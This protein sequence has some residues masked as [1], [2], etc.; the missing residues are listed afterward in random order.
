MWGVHTRAGESLLFL[1]KGM[2]C[3]LPNLLLLFWRLH[4]GILKT[5]FLEGESGS[6]PSSQMW[7]ELRTLWSHPLTAPK[8][9]SLDDSGSHQLPGREAQTPHLRQNWAFPLCCGNR[10]WGMQSGLSGWGRSC[11]RQDN[12][13]VCPR[14][15]GA[16]H[17]R[18][19][20]VHP[21]GSPRS[22]AVTHELS[23]P[24]LTV[25]R[26]GLRRSVSSHWSVPTWSERGLSC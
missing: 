7:R 3:E 4:F 5:D 2:V 14:A 15:G 24:W 26:S 22:A 23:A 6:L 25:A 12:G 16:W 19:P 1:C 21:A 20:A 11:R 17:S 18:S 10:V 13:A 8:P 9:L